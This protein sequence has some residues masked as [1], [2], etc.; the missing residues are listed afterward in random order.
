MLETLNLTVHDVVYFEHNP[1][2]V[3]SAQSVGII[4]YYYNSG[5]RDL[6]AL[7]DFLTKNLNT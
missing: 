6:E 5:K 7:K 3:K 4:T 2:A 1:E